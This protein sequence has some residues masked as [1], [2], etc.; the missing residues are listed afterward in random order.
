MA[1][2]RQ[3]LDPLQAARARRRILFIL[4]FAPDLQARDGGTRAM[5][6]LIT[7]MA[8]RHEIHVLYLAFD[9]RPPAIEPPTV[10]ASLRGVPMASRKSNRAMRY[11]RLATLRDPDWAAES[12]GKAMQQ[13]IAQTLQATR[14]DVV[15]CEFHVMAQYLPDVIAHAPAAIRIVTEHEPGICAGQTTRRKLSGA[16]RILAWL[17]S[18]GWARYERRFLP[19][20]DAVITFTDED[21]RAVRTLLGPTGPP[22]ETVPL[23]VPP[24]EEGGPEPSAFEES[25]LLFFGNFGHLPNVEAAMR[26][27]RDLCPRLLAHRPDVKIA[28]VGPNPPAELLALASDNVRVTGAV[29]RI[30]P[31][32]AGAK[33]VVA[34]IA[35]GGGTR[36]KVLE[37]LAAGKALVATPLA[38]AGLCVEA[39]QQCEIAST[40]GEFVDLAIALLADEAR[41][42]RLG[43]VARIWARR[44]LDGETWVDDYESVYAR[45]LSRRRN[46]Q[47]GT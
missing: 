37:T 8:G 40:D 4:P 5:T 33:L 26:L 45:A 9:N 42:E 11:L 41:R 14:F 17:G 6:A 39:G 35:T 25:D 31:W 28:I 27:A 36:V 32:L 43:K 1:E 30:A 19:L 18:R 3:S 20:A 38:V 16:R 29:D 12:R 15:H 2:E 34:P 23:R 10:C 13:A 47:E 46:R 21:G 24:A 7:A 22:V 44:E